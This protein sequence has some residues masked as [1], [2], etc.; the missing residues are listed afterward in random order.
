MAKEKKARRTY[1]T[2][3]LPFGKQ[4]IIT[5]LAYASIVVLS[6]LAS[7]Y[8]LLFNFA[9]FDATKFATKL[10]IS[11][12]IAIMALLMAIK[13]GK[14][15]N[16]SKKKGDYYEAKQKFKAKVEQLANKDWFRQWADGVLYPRERKSAICAILNEYG[17]TEYEYMLISKEDLDALQSEPKICVIGKDEDGRE[18]KKPLDAISQNQHKLL[19]MMRD[20]FRFKQLDYS[21][22]TSQS[23]GGGYAYYASLKDNQRKRKIF[24]LCYRVFMILATTTIFALAVINP[25]DESAAQV[26]FDTTGRITTLLSSV[27]MGYTLAN[28]EM[29]ENI[30]AIA[31][32]IEKIDEYLIEK[33]SGAFVPVSK[34]EEIRKRI[35]EIERKRAEEAERAAASVVVAEIVKPGSAEPAEIEYRE[36]EMTEDEFKAFS[37]T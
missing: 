31:F 18:I 16:E 28:D 26:A 15:T 23:S 34:D 9:N 17:I 33:E 24:A 7:C 32:K 13:D 12:C 20:G 36:V 11:I 14:T 2:A 25:H 8:E 3:N 5:W 29:A 21:Y 27:F 1:A 19:T 4:R 6:V 30:D 10:S 22:F 35:E 37:G